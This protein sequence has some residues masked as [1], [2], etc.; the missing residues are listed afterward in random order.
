MRKSLLIATA[1][2]TIALAGIAGVGL[3]SAASDNTQGTLVDKLVAKFHLNE[4]QAAHQAEEKTRLDQ[5]VKDG[6]LTQAQEDKI[7]AHEAEEKTLMDSL[8]G[9]TEAERH[10]AMEANRTAEQK[11]ATDNGIP[12]EF[13]RGPGGHG[14]HRGGR[15]G[16]SDSDAPAVT[17]G[18]TTTK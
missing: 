18:T 5:A 7:V 13:L 4:N 10:T 9:K 16:G 12:T 2:T 6:K 15:W 11:W 8:A 14:G 17:P 1:A 3:V